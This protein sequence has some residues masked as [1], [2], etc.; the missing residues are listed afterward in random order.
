MR[1]FPAVRKLIQDVITFVRYGDDGGICDRNLE[2]DVKAAEAEI[3]CYPDDP[4]I[5]KK[6][7]LEKL[8]EIERKL[9]GL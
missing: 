4:A 1:T 2:A 3:D 6:L 9:L 7:A 8:N 5:V